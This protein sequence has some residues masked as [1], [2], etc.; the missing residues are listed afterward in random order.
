MPSLS[1]TV[2]PSIDVEYHV[3]AIF[4]GNENWKWARQDFPS[5]PPGFLA[6]VG[7]FAAVDN[8]PPSLARPCDQ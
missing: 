1:P 2:I 6:I 8:I 7:S 5:A 3:C 4:F